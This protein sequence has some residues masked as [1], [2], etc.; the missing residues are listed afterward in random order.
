M[1]NCIGTDFLLVVLCEGLIE[2]P[3]GDR[4]PLLLLFSQHK[5]DYGQHQ[6][7]NRQCATA[8]IPRRTFQHMSLPCGFSALCYHEK[9]RE[10]KAIPGWGAFS[11]KQE[12]QRSGILGRE[13]RKDSSTNKNIRG[14]KLRIKLVSLNFHVPLRQATL[15]RSSRSTPCLG[16]GF[17]FPGIQTLYIQQFFLS[18][19][20]VCANGLLLADS[21]LLLRDCGKDER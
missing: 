18:R 2:R 19:H 3:A 20:T 1:R 7:Q 17:L 8:Y 14:S 12:N 10:G 16:V 6:P 5:C 21:E 9:N 15:P 4:H 13:P 11:I